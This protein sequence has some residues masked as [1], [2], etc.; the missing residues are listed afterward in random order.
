MCV[1]VGVWYICVG[2]CIDEGGLGCA[3]G[4]M[5]ASGWAQRFIR[6]G[7]CVGINL[8]VWVCVY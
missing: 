7:W 2:A 4:V 8:F 6:D 1:C 5:G 3:K